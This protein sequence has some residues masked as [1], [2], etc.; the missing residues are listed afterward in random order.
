M[1][2]NQL[3]PSGVNDLA[4]LAAFAATP[5]EAFVEPAFAALAYLDRDIPA[6]KG[7][8]RL[9]LAPAALGRL[10]QAAKP[11]PRERA[12]D[13]AGGSAYGACVL[14]RL[15]LSV[16]ALE[17][18]QSGEGARA[19]V[20]GQER[21]EIVNGDL[22]AGFAAKAPFD[23]IVVNGAFEIWPEQLI[24]QL[25]E[26]GRLV[27]FDASFSAPKAVLIEKAG[28]AVS[29]RVIGDFAAPHLDDFK[30]PPQFA[31]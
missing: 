19:A 16:V 27:G 2:D 28:G 10:T 9:L 11:Q 20:G 26:G 25:A 8:G 13:V 12:L 15:G 7:R 18:P 24:A 21:V 22:P 31:F 1:V 30:R 14:A 29:R 23:V 3:R 17:T 6:L 5:R 4:L